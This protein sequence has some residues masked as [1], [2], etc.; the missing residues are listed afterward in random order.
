MRI[1]DA[2]FET[3]VKRCIGVVRG[4][5]QH[6]DEFDESATVKEQR[7]EKRGEL[8]I[9]LTEGTIMYKYVPSITVDVETVDVAVS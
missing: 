2:I 1:D 4:F 8:V 3:D 9:E 7:A 6:G 5:D